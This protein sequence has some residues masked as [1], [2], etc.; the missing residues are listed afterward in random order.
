MKISPKLD[1]FVVIGAEVSS[2]IASLAGFL[3]V[4][5]GVVGTGGALVPLLLA[6]SS[7]ITLLKTIHIKGL[8]DR[9]KDQRLPSTKKIYDELQNKEIGAGLALGVATIGGGVLTTHS[10]ASAAATISVLHPAL[11]LLALGFAINALVEFYDNI[12]QW[13]EKVNDKNNKSYDLEDVEDVEAAA[14]ENQE[15]AAARNLAI[16]SFFKFLGWSC[17]VTGG[18][19]LAAPFAPWLIPAGLA[20]VAGSHLY[21]NFITVY[22]TPATESYE[23]DAQQGCAKYF[24]PLLANSS[25]AV[26]GS[27]HL[28]ETLGL[29]LV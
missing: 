11:S 7:C 4:A 18:F 9:K 15:V 10:A 25:R 23:Q 22:R 24:F 20:V 8:S 26:S 21:N 3:C 19:A 12:H 13:Q 16:S 17:V 5:F 2:T 27:S 28:D 14:L 6:S 1:T 29:Q